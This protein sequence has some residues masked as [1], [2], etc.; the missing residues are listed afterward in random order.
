MFTTAK[1]IYKRYDSISL[2]IMVDLFVVRW[3]TNTRK[4]LVSNLPWEE[5]PYLKNQNIDWVASVK[6]SLI[7][8]QKYSS[9]R[10][11]LT[12]HCQT[13]GPRQLVTR[14]GVLQREQKIWFE[15]KLNTSRKRRLIKYFRPS[16][17]NFVKIFKPQIWTLI[18]K[19]LYQ[20]SVKKDLILVRTE[21][22][23]K[24]S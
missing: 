21:L 17:R 3:I 16:F 8:L 12:F 9:S 18:A 11:L 14:F 5:L 20:V 10:Q 13:D 6:I 23:L 2:C 22:I 4:C 19:N 15:K 7:Y 24:V 1:D